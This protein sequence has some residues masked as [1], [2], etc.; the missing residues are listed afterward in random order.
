MMVILNIS[1][2]KSIQIQKA[3]DANKRHAVIPY[4]LVRVNF[5]CWNFIDLMEQQFLS[6]LDVE[7]LKL[8]VIRMIRFRWGS[9]RCEQVVGRSLFL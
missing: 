3:I 8:R 7:D 5:Y 4:R 2:S 9:W 1:V 6:Y